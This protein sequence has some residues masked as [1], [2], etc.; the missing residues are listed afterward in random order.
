MQTHD[1]SSIPLEKLSPHASRKVIHTERMTVARLWLKAGAVVPEHH[2]ENEQVTML[3]SGRL[4]FF[5]EGDVYTVSA[6]QTLVI[7]PNVPH[8]VEAIEDS[9][10]TD[11]FSPVREDWLRGDDAYLRGGGPR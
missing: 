4:L 11:L 5:M 9:E 2:H 7:P 10:A 8:R 1:W 3:S 6:G